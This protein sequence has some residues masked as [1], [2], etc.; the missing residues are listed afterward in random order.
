MLQHRII[1]I[2]C[3]EYNS[4]SINF[5]DFENDKLKLHK[6]KLIIDYLNDDKEDEDLIKE[7]FIRELLKK[8]KDYIKLNIKL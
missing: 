2:R 8:L 7:G 4:D 6:P 3:K 5:D 1:F